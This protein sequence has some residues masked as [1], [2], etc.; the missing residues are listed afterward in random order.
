[1]VTPGNT[2]F[3][4]TADSSAPTAGA[5]TVNGTA[6]T[7][8]GSASYDTDGS[9]AIDARTDYAETASATESGLASSTLTRESATLSS[10]S[11]GGF[12]SATTLAGTPAQ[13]GLATGCYRYRL[14]GT[15]NVGNA[16]SLRSE[17]HTSELQSPD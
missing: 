9:F 10:D 2:T 17:E 14:T 4:V 16:V 5:L 7:G 15:D 11:C 3:D 12:G 1:G 13:S 6:A 8:G